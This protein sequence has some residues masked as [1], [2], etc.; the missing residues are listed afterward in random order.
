MQR[1]LE[2]GRFPSP[3]PLFISC[4]LLGSGGLYATHQNSGPNHIPKKRVNK[5]LKKMTKRKNQIKTLSD[6]TNS[7]V[8]VMYKGKV[9]KKPSSDL[10]HKHNY[11]YQYP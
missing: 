6:E 7:C 11:G 1:F 4:K 3:L 8:F 9:P 10:R 5:F 2:N